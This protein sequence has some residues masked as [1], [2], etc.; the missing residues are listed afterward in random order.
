MPLS[1]QG[2]DQTTPMG[3]TP[4][5]GGTTFRVWAGNATAVYLV[6]DAA[7]AY[8]PTD[9][10]RLLPMAAPGHWAGFVP[11]VG[12][13]R[14]YR[15]WVVGAGGQGFKRDPYARELRY[16]DGVVTP[17]YDNSNCIVRSPSSYRWAAPSF[18]GPRFHELIVYQFHVGVFYGRDARNRDVRGGVAKLLHAAERVPYL[19]DLG[20]NAVQPL[21]FVEFWTESSIGYNGTDLF[22]PEMDYCMSPAQLDEILPRLNGLLRAR[23]APE[24]TRVEL[25][26]HP[27]QLKLFIDL[28]HLYG[29]AVIVDVVYNHAGPSFN[30]QS[31]EHFDLPLAPSQ[32]NKLYFHKGGA[33]WVGPV[34]DYGLADVRE[35]LLDNARAFLNEYRVDGFRFDEVRVIGWNG[36]WGFL[37][38]MTSTLRFVNPS[39]VLIA[40]FWDDVREGAV[41]PRDANG[42]GFDVEY[43]DRFRRAMREVLAAAAGGKSARLDLDRLRDAL[44]P[45]LGRDDAW[46]SYNCLENHDLEDDNHRPGEKEP[47]IA[48]LAGGNDARSWYA[49]SRARVATS[50]L[51]TAPGIP[52][53]FM[54]QEFLEYKY[55]SD[56]FGRAELF[57]DW[58]G[59]ESGRRAMR[60][61]HRFVRE[62]CWLRRTR[63][64][65]TGGGINVFHVHEQNR[66][67]ALQ[68]WAEGIGQDVVIVASLAEDTYYGKSYR[69][70]FP[71]PGHW[72]EI[73]NSDVY[74]NYFNHDAQGN[75]GG[76]DTDP[77]PLHGFAQSAGI[78]IPANGVVM[79]ARN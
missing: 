35:F 37:Q 45:R 48:A 11:N 54:G 46:R 23:G 18:R 59:L 71:A 62:L 73:F 72:E 8:T 3:A 1:Q 56:N 30:R 5:R 76:I 79:F 65:L 39:A 29:I 77:Q 69:I 53:L 74:E 41:R 4:T 20:V 51:L 19:A 12:D 22:S 27:N 24:K 64:A 10:D 75:Y 31:I 43:E 61:F 60:D 33:E 57:I 42:A 28:C 70:G 49:T 17:D 16:L 36:G 21:P 55:W 58:D 63:A 32:F 15:F 68:R 34:F 47:R 13:G 67:I 9:A 38:D 25:E 40:E 44:Y 7:T 52:M 78:T 26:P 2:I 14:P 50:L 66:V 6:L